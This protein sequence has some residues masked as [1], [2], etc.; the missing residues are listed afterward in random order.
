MQKKGQKRNCTQKYPE[1]LSLIG[2]EGL[3]VSPPADHVRQIRIQVNLSQSPEDPGVL[4]R[5]SRVVQEVAAALQMP[6]Q[7][8]QALQRFE[9]FGGELDLFWLRFCLI[10]LI[11]PRIQ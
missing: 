1:F 3:D 5:G 6:V 9:R 11:N 4:R 8:V 7:G 2:G 10:C